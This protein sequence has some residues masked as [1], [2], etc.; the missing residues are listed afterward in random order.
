MGS[1]SAA[2]PDAAGLRLA[3]PCHSLRS[4]D[5]A[6]GGAP[7][8]PHIRPQNLPNCGFNQRAH[9]ECAPTLAY[10]NRTINRNL[11]AFHLLAQKTGYGLRQLLIRFHQGPVIFPQQQHHAAHQIPLTQN[12]RRHAQVILIRAFRSL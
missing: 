10:G 3:D 11:S 12:G 1:P 7:I 2:T 8:A 9:I 6:T 4:L 5:P